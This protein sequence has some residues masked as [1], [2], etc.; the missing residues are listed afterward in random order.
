MHYISKDDSSRKTENRNSTENSKKLKLK[1]SKIN[2][3]AP[4]KTE[5][6]VSKNRS[7]KFFGLFLGFSLSLKITVII[8]FDVT[9]ACALPNNELL[10]FLLNEVV[11]ATRL[12]K[13]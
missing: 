5:K 12:L 13:K 8:H 7:E 9:P 6:S 1:L 3:K 11:F 10:I 4:S 2:Q